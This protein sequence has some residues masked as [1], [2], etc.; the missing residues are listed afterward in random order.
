MLTYFYC[1]RHHRICRS[2]IFLSS[3]FGDGASVYR[4][5]YICLKFVCYQ[6]L[7]VLTRYP[8]R[9]NVIIANKFSDNNFYFILSIANN[10]NVSLAMHW[11]NDVIVK[12]FTISLIYIVITVV[13]ISTV[14]VPRALNFRW[15]YI[16]IM[17]TI[18]FC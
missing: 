1:L 8:F 11:F 18:T 7:L 6:Y 17:I 10:E 2:L 16:Y 5:W 15:Q 12:H 13:C 3:L 4:P 9:N 14:Q